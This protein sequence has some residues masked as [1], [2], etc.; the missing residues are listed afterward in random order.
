MEMVARMTM[1]VRPLKSH[2]RELAAKLVVAEDL[3]CVGV[4]VLGF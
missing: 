1:Q 3:K 2:G 4:F